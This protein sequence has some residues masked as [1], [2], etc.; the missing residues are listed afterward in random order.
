M[1]NQETG[2]NEITEAAPAVNPETKPQYDNKW[3]GVPPKGEQPLP[4]KWVYVFMILGVII[5]EI[6]IWA[7]YRW[8][9]AEFFQSFGTHQFYLLHIIA[10]PAIHL[11]PIL[12]FWR[13]IRK[14]R[15][16]PFVFTKKLLLSGIIVGFCAAII[17]RLLEEFAYDGFAGIAGGTVP[18]TLSF[19]N[20]L[21]TADMFILMTFVMYFIVGPVEEFEFR[22]FT[23]D[24]SARVLTNWQA[25]IF[26]SVL[27]G[28]SHIPIG[29]F[30]YQFTATQ[31]IDA[32]ISWISA[33]FVLGA[34]YM[35][36]RNI[37]A[38]IIMH[39]MGNWQLSVFYFESTSSG[40]M[41]PNTS[42]AVG[43]ATSIIVN[44][45]MIIIFYLIH[46]YYWQP[47]RRGESAFGG[48]L[49]SLQNYIHDHD[50][51]KKPVQTTITVSVVF[52]VIISGII[53]GATITI[54]KTPGSGLE[55]ETDSESSAGLK[56]LVD[57]GE[58]QEGL[59]ELTE[60]MG[61]MIQLNSEFEKYI[62]TITLTVTWTDEPDR[63]LAGMIEN[64][65]DTFS[66]LIMGP[67][68]S[69]SDQGSNPHG[70]E[71][72]I[73]AE[74]AFSQEEVKQMIESD[75]ENYEIIISINLEDAGNY[76]PGI[77]A[78]GDDGNESNYQLDIVWL[79][80]EE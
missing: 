51:G 65:P 76:Q 39:A 45:I 80:P 46:K 61:M 44:A 62:K 79:M 47:H 28:C 7:I 43:I 29:I 4:D 77:G 8:T 30:V 59:G 54:G 41:A 12:L 48:I 58:T 53:M 34:L 38:C 33:G 19:L 78:I 42:M 2:S 50:F 10:A 5:S 32:L 11:I 17:W 49:L 60:G 25:L 69:A 13:Y 71:G 37:L 1:I 9:T 67:N 16:I 21:E 66:I 6:C 55:N 27:F 73:T 63:G 26:S 70:G 68:A 15:G 3:Y 18:G 35:W 57:T 14:E 20:I 74:L 31:F 36:S 22:G 56:N 64:Q 75:G 40:G 52:I 24:Q 23:H 72:R